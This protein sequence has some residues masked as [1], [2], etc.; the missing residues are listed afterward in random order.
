[1]K[2]LSLLDIFYSFPISNTKSFIKFLIVSVMSRKIK[3]KF[4]IWTPFKLI[5]WITIVEMDSFWDFK[6]C[7]NFRKISIFILHNSNALF[8]SWKSFTAL[9]FG[10]LVSEWQSEMTSYERI[11]K[12]KRYLII[13]YTLLNMPLLIHIVSLNWRKIRS[14]HSAVPSL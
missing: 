10:P 6:K 9:K 1:M 5:H 7:Q 11:I 13:C 2:I 8:I 3:Y 4:Q 12:L 14:F